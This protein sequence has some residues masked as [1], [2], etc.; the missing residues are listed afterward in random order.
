MA[1]RLQLAP[2][3]TPTTTPG[4]TMVPLTRGPGKS[5][6]V[7]ARLARATTMLPVSAGFLDTRRLP[8]VTA[9]AGA[10]LVC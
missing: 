9:V 6:L 2:A 5:V 1:V 8:D 3:R 4:A 7:V 10:G